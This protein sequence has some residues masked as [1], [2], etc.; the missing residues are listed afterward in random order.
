MI[1]FESLLM[2][3]ASDAGMKVP[4]DPDKG[5]SAHE[6]PHFQVFCTLQLARPMSSPSQHWE[7]AKI[8]AAVPE[9]KIRTMKLDDFVALGVDMN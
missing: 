9:D 1:V 4:D 2:K 7:N 8:I 6:F 3:P 5:F